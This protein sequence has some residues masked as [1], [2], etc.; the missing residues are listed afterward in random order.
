MPARRLILLFAV[1]ASV[2]ARGAGTDDFPSKAMRIVVPYTAGGVVDVRARWIA[3]RLAKNLGKPVIVDNRPGPDTVIGADAVAKAVADGHTILMTGGQTTFI[4]T[5]ILL[6]QLP[7]DPAKDFAPVTPYA[8]A[9]MVLVVPP[10]L[11]VSSVKALIALAKAKP[12]QLNYGSSGNGTSAHIAGEAF[13]HAAGLDILHVP[14]KGDAPA[15]TDALAGHV[16]MNFTFAVTCAEF[17]RSGKL[18]ALMQTG[19]KR[20]ANL[21]DVPT[22]AE[23]GLPELTI[24]AWGGIWAPGRTPLA[25]VRRLNDELTKILRSQEYIEWTRSG[26]SEP[27]AS[28][29]EEFAVFIE[30]ERVRWSKLMRETGV[31]VER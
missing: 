16:S 31:R 10:S 18:L 25:R 8:M 15:L 26:G 23:L 6:A 7:Y 1:L 3:E 29:P 30:A 5:P 19:N 21:P 4:T 27:R 17:V 20:L 13:K 24:Y 28:T 14:Y 9:P 2:F 11:G 12:G 22:A